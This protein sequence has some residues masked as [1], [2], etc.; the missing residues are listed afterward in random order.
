MRLLQEEAKPEVPQLAWR[1]PFSQQA[2]RELMS[3]TVE[4]VAGLVLQTSV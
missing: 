1:V 3:L 2:V 4:E